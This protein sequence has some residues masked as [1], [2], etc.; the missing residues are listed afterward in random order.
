MKINGKEIEYKAGETVLQAAIRNG[1]EI[2][3][4]CY[5][6]HVDH[7]ASCMLCVVKD[8]NSESIFPSCS[9][10]VREEMDLLTDD[11]EL[12][13]MR[14]TSLE[15]LLSDHVG[16]CEAPC[17]L[18][19]PAF[20]DI[21]QM[22]RLLAEEKYDQALAVV[23]NNIA[24]PGVLGR[25][26]PAPCEKACK[27]K[28]IDDPVSICLLKRS[29]D[30]FG[31]VPQ[32]KVEVNGKR[33]AV[34]GAG[35][36]G[37]S[38]AYY[39]QLK[40]YQVSVLDKNEEPGGNLR[41]EVPQEKLDREVLDADIQ[42]I[43]DLG[44]QFVMNNRLTKEG[45][46]K[47][48][49]DFDA[50]ILALGDSEISLSTWGLEMKGEHLIADKQTFETII[51]K[52]FAIGNAL[53][54]SK[55]SIRALGHGRIAAESVDQLLTD[56]EVNGEPRIFNSR[57]GFLLEEEF[58]V[59]LDEATKDAR[60]PKSVDKQEGFTK[61]E[62][63]KEAKRCMH[64]DCRAMDDCK[65]RDYSHLFKAKQSRYA[66]GSRKPITKYFEHEKIVYEPQKCIR[67]GICV[68][69]TE[70]HKEEL[71]LTFIGRGFNVEIGIPYG[72]SLVKALQKTEIEVASACP[73]GALEF[74]TKNDETES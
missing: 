39:L 31:N 56:K 38:A 5:Y 9:Q 68:R 65:L 62:L 33:V 52:V 48:Q 17:T 47:L 42:A 60:N 57:F 21:P 15:L 37:L 1:I 4:M 18:T 12:F 61:E 36:A 2:P 73:T 20:M 14:K 23:K 25:I 43:R 6:E 35:P 45:F 69:I 41:Y 74:K 10:A 29:A 59:Y 51:P 26:C 24:M 8:V 13:E 49:A 55:Y 54:T 16:D 63:V 53:R 22:N 72:D 7:F 32:P 46:Q 11:E 44:V 71:G 30:D 66:I 70:K 67:C 50:V 19:C 28:V 58:E 27:R 3:N 40:G 34:V 64:C